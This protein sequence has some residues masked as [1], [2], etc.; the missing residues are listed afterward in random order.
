MD[1]RDAD[2]IA[3]SVN[4]FSNHSKN[5]LGIRLSSE[6]IEPFMVIYIPSG[7]DLY[8]SHRK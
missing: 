1:V 2:K 4:I 8:F 6:H 7:K 3:V 5:C